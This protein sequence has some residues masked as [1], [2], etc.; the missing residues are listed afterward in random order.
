V[1]LEASAEDNDQVDRVT[2]W[3]FD[4]IQ[5]QW[6]STETF[7]A[8]YQTSFSSNKLVPGELYYFEVTARDRAGNMSDPEQRRYIY[9]IGGTSIFLP[10][11]IR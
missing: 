11:S 3:W 9:I 8:P 5:N 4:H 2:F 6:T 10:I 7:T 1:T